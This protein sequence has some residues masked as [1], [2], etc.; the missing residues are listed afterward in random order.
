MRFSKQD[1]R[2]IL[3]PIVIEQLLAVTIGMADSMMV[4]SAGEAAISG[5]SLVDTVNLLLLFMFSALSAGG[6]VVISQTLGKG[7][8]PL[9]GNAA[10]QLVWVVLAVSG[11][12]T[13]AVLVFRKPLLALIFGK[14][15]ADVMSNALTYFFFTSLSYPF[16][17]LYNSHAAIF[18]AMG[19]SKT[20]LVASV[21]MNVSN[22]IG[23]AVLIFVF[24][25]GAAGAAISTLSSRV[26]GSVMMMILSRNR[27]NT[28]YIDSLF[29]CKFEKAV[30]KR[31]CAIGIPNGIEN[32]MF[33]LG[34]IL[35]QSLISTFGTAQIAANA[36]GNNLVAFQYSAGGAAGIAMIT[37]VGQC[38]GAGEKNEAKKY[39]AKL[40]RL[41][42]TM[43]ISVSL[44]TCIF[45]YPLTGLYDLSPE[46]QGTAIKLVIAHSVAASIMHPMAFCV[47]NSFR[48][49]SDV[50]YPMIMS[51]ISMWV[52]R[53][54]FSYVLGLY[55]HMGVMGV[56]LAMFCDWIFRATLYTIRFKRGTWLKKYKPLEV[57]RQ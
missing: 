15:E 50:K 2:R 26:I 34:K 47:A 56:W 33:Q 42:Y 30:V 49:A 4:S 52:F 6:S 8:V 31:I 55:F 28:L 9:A 32:S 48:A 41:A 10:K 27:N 24:H 7:D 51:I 38:I 25:M 54:G 36:V 45:I 20:P 19:N 21:V 5:V 3:I 18:R 13:T 35:T 22:L 43:L 44:I 39:A 46:A 23:N 1:M 16:I 53:V 40:L 17:G 57:T 29:K 37:I 14:V 12:L 11:T